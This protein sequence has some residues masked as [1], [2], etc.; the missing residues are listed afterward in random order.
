MAYPGQTGFFQAGVPGQMHSVGYT[1][2]DG[3]EMYGPQFAAASTNP[4][5]AAAPATIAPFR[6]GGAEAGPQQQTHQVNP[7]MPPGGFDSAGRYRGGG[8]EPMQQPAAPQPAAPQPGAYIGRQPMQAMEPGPTSNPWMNNA[9]DWLTR[10]ATQTLNRD[11]LPAMGRGAQAVGGYGDSRSNM[12]Q[13]LAV[14]DTMKNLTGQLGSLAFN[15]YNTDNNF[16]LQ[17][18]L[19]NQNVMRQGQ[20]DQLNLADR[21][22]GWNQQYGIG[23]ATNV[24]NTPLNYWQQFANT[25]AQLGGLGGTSTQNMQGNPWLGALGGYQLG[26]SLFGG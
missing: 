8:F 18:W 23:N 3:T 2:S 4:G 9:A 13:S 6:S 1:I 11:I 12:L 16:D 17:S 7:Y 26:R 19:A 21:L 14:G 25:G 10:Q 15:Q 20:Q 22:L 5:P 24:Q